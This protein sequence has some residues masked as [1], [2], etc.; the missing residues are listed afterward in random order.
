MSTE[1]Q[2]VPATVRFRI[3]AYRKSRLFLPPAKIQSKITRAV[4]KRESKLPV[5]VGM[6]LAASQAANGSGIAVTVA[7]SRTAWLITEVTREREG[8]KTTWS[9]AWHQV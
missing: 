2:Y 3:K 6:E 1:Q 4:A 8:A 5:K 9:G 7:A